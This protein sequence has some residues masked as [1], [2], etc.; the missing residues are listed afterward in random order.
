MCFQINSEFA[1]GS[2][3]MERGA[4]SSDLSVCCTAFLC[5]HFSLWLHIHVILLCCIVVLSCVLCS[6]ACF[7]LQWF[8]PS[9]RFLSHPTFSRSPVSFWPGPSAFNLSYDVLFCSCRY[10][11]PL[12]VAFSF[13]FLRVVYCRSLLLSRFS[14]LR[15]SP[16][17]TRLTVY[18][19]LSILLR[20]NRASS[21]VRED[22]D[23]L[24]SFLIVSLMFWL[25]L[26]I[27][28]HKNC[29]LYIKAL[30]FD[31]RIVERLWKA[32]LESTLLIFINC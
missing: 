11:L 7:V 24:V 22:V 20:S 10:R 28:L 12:C 18:R 31:R 5:F 25:S 13:R 29:S 2:T 9:A 27:L 23:F 17:E 4:F 15:V 1:A 30:V 8:H 19:R 21:G 26:V 6:S 32:S 3:K 16:A 14:A